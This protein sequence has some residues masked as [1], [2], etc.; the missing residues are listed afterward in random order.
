[1]IWK[2]MHETGPDQA[3]GKLDWHDFPSIC[4]SR[5]R[6]TIESKN[7][8]IDVFFRACISGMVGTLNLY[9]DPALLYTWWEAS[10][11]VAK[12]VGH[13]VRHACN[14]CAWIHA[15]LMSVKLPVHCYS[16]FHSS[17]LDDEDFVM[18]IQLHL[19]QL[20]KDNYIWAE[21]I[22]EFIMTPDIQEYLG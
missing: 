1:M 22:V 16:W 9:L 15:Y 3:L 7:K 20:R 5:A 4:L 19:Q 14:L 6:L 10:L 11:I 8:A 2:T 21:D 18:A 12:A 13:G 17:L